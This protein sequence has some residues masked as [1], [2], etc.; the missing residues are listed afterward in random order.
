MNSKLNIL[1]YWAEMNPIG[2]LLYIERKLSYLIYNHYKVKVCGDMFQNKR[3]IMLLRQAY[4]VLLSNDK[5]LT[6]VKVKCDLADC[7]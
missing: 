4:T 7:Y 6:I 1:P 3:I 5:N 2:V